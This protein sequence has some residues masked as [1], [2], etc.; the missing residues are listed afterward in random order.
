MAAPPD[1]TGVID[2]LAQVRACHHGTRHA[3]H[4]RMAWHSL[5]QAFAATPHPG[6]R[7][8]PCSHS[9]LQPLPGLPPSQSCPRYQFK[10]ALNRGTFGFVNLYEHVQ[11]GELVAIKFLERGEKVNKYV[12]D[13]ILNHRILR[14]PHVIE[15]KVRSTGKG[16]RRSACWLLQTFIRG[17][18]KHSAWQAPGSM[19]VCW[20]CLTGHA[21]SVA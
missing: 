9:D 15:F 11:T 10:K 3:H 12:K 14:H 13:E 1:L 5:M 17:I 16:S 21:I 18:R 4:Y 8:G 7:L 2:P 6:M 19:M 20:V